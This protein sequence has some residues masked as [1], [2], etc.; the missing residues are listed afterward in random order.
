MGEPPDAGIRVDHGDA[1]AGPQVS[2]QNHWL[3][4]TDMKISGTDVMAL[5]GRLGRLG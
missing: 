3:P 5:H 1:H 2:L 4:M